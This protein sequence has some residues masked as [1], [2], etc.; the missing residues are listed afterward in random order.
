MHK[1]AWDAHECT[2]VHDNAQDAYECISVRANAGDAHE[3]IRV[4]NI[5]STTNIEVGFIKY[6]C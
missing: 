2:R 3:C 5:V 6:L 4:H 1:N